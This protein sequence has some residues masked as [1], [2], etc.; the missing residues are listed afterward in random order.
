MNDFTKEELKH[1]TR[2]LLYRLR[3]DPGERSK[4]Y[5][6]AFHDGIVMMAKA[7]EQAIWEKQELDNEG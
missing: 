2:S 1:L 5:S 7:Y 6:N 4:Q 3:I